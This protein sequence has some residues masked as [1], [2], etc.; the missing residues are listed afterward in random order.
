[1][2]IFVRS[3]ESRA[4]WYSDQDGCGLSYGLPGDGP[5]EVAKSRVRAAFEGYVLELAARELAPR[6]G[7]GAGSA[8]NAAAPG[9]ERCSG[10]GVCPRDESAPEK[11]AA[12]R[13]RS[14]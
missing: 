2:R 3:R 8:G 12:S 10:D 13:M 6:S 4:E 1:M 14:P 7:R 5:W 11:E 9:K